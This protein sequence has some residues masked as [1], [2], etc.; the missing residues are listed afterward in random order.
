MASP[1]FSKSSYPDPISPKGDCRWTFDADKDLEKWYHFE[2]FLSLLEVKVTFSYQESDFILS[3]KC[4]ELL[5]NSLEYSR[6]LDKC[7]KKFTL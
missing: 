5:S 7:N 2:A 3:F 1:V 6:E 4:Y